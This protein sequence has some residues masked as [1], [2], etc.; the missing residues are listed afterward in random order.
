MKNI[1]TLKI[2]QK[3]TNGST[4][5]VFELT[6]ELT[7]VN[8]ET[9]EVIKLTECTH[10][11]PFKETI[12]KTVVEHNQEQTSRVMMFDNKNGSLKKRGFVVSL[13]MEI[14]ENVKINKENGID[15]IF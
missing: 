14:S 12:I 7:A 1:T 3:F 6:G 11:Y 4:E 9:K 10:V 15:F 2:G 13:N 5:T 8:L